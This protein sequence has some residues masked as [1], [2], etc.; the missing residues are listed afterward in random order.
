MSKRL[1]TYV[2]MDELLKMV[3]LDVARYFFIE[4][5]ADTHLNF[6][7]D[8]ARKRS[9]KNPVY[10]IQYAYARICSI[11]KKLKNRPARLMRAGVR[12]LNLLAHPSELKLIK[13]LVRFPELVEEVSGNYQIQRIPQYALDLATVFHQFYR[14]CRVISKDENTSRAR[15]ALLLATKIVLKNTLDLMGISAPERM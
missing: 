6:D 14:D 13:Q 15:L 4:R 12:D 11:L 7:I 1:G 10:Y 2:T 8:L 5:N 3:G 9:E